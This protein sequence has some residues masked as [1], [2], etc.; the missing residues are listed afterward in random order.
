M[1][2]IQGLELSDDRIFWLRYMGNILLG[3]VLFIGLSIAA[4]SLMNSTIAETSVFLI[5]FG[6]DINSYVM[7]GATIANVLI[8]LYFIANAYLKISDLTAAAGILVGV[9]VFSVFM[10]FFWCHESTLI[11]FT[12]LS[13]I[14]GTGSILIFFPIASNYHPSYTSALIL[15]YN[16]CGLI[17][18]A[19]NAVQTFGL[20][21]DFHFDPTVYFIFVAMIAFTASL[22][23]I[24]IIKLIEPTEIYAEDE[25]LRSG[26]SVRIDL[27]STKRLAE[28]KHSIGAVL[29]EVWPYLLIA[30]WSSIIYNYIPGSFPVLGNREGVKWLNL[31][32]LAFP[33]I[34][35]ITGAFVHYYDIF[36]LLII[37]TLL[38]LPV[39]MA[40]VFQLWFVPPNFVYYII[41]G[42]YFAN[43][44][45]FNTMLFLRPRRDFALG[46]LKTVTPEK[47][48]RFIALCSI[49]GG[50]TGSLIDAFIITSINSNTPGSGG[51][52]VDTWKCWQVTSNSSYP[53][54]A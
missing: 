17:G 5:F 19:L 28:K 54:P 50:V 3:Y 48:S 16:V 25:R 32:Y 43:Q 39:F 30:F 35:A 7:L 36:I 38:F 21:N 23:Y 20:E 18:A 4:Q 29:K 11:I 2:H 51:L 42:L 41:V 37:Q 40:P 6:P 24:G 53:Q 9:V 13:A 10:A 26:S 45:F 15:G 34:G 52:V 8:L 1:V 47:I 46:K 27:L 44:G 49:V 33:G 31:E 12:S 14:L 22:S